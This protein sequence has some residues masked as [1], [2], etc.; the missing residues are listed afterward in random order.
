[1]QHVSLLCLFTELRWLCNFERTIVRTTAN[2]QA[3]VK[4]GSFFFL[5][6][7]YINIKIN[8]LAMAVVVPCT[9]SVSLKKKIKKYNLCSKSFQLSKRGGDI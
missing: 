1:M 7:L 2:V 6:E 9:A 8:I 3:Y 4:I 5:K